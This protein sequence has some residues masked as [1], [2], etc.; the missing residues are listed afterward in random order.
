MLSALPRF[1][2]TPSHAGAPLR[3]SAHSRRRADARRL[4]RSKGLCGMRFRTYYLVRLLD[5]PGKP[6]I[7]MMTIVFGANQEWIRSEAEAAEIAQQ[8]LGPGAH[9][10]LLL[11]LAMFDD[12]GTIVRIDCD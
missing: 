1:P 9:F 5:Q 2:Y 8:L 12:D 11:R 7:E 6:G 3:G 4:A 10:D